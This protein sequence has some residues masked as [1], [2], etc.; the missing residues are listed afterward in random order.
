[1]YS[2]FLANWKVRS[3]LSIPWLRARINA[4]DPPDIV[5][6][7][8]S[9]PDP[10]TT[11]LIRTVMVT[12]YSECSIV[13]LPGLVRFRVEKGRSI[14]MDIAPGI[15]P[16]EVH[17]FLLGTGLALLCYQ[18]KLVPFRGCAVCNEKRSIAVLGPSG[19][20]KSAVAAAFLQRGYRLIA[21]EIV[22]LDPA[23]GNVLPT[24]P[25]VKLWRDSAEVLGISSEVLVRTRPALE[26]YYLDV[27]DFVPDSPP[28]VQAVFLL[29]AKRSAANPNISRLFGKAVL[30][31]LL[32]NRCF[33]K[34]DQEP[35]TAGRNFMACTRLARQ[36]VYD[37]VRTH[38]FGKLNELM[39][40]LEGA[41]EK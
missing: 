27:N 13:E 35:N 29:N 28:P 25:A 1:M 9:F 7:T 12:V 40:L 16:A 15:N 38:G 26:K 10:E 36:P 3:A 18:R 20:G 4:D 34:L 19:V 22:I 8:G 41:G 30:P 17:P 31:R 24:Y 23:T 11:P 2:Y 39:D 5:I 37:A 14:L 32:S 6:E 21:D 33:P